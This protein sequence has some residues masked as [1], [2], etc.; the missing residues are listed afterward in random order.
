MFSEKVAPN[1]ETDVVKMAAM[2]VIKATH[3]AIL[4]QT[5]VLPRLPC[6]AKRLHR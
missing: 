6:R 5:M 4:P 2:N 1:F 3:A